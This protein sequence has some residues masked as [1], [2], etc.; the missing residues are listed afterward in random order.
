MN[1]F[2][3]KQISKVFISTPIT[4]KSIEIPL[5][6]RDYAQGRPEEKLRRDSFLTN[7]FNTINSTDNNAE[8]NLDF[9]YG[10]IKNGLFIPLD[11]QQRLTTLILL[12]FYAAIRENKLEEFSKIP[13]L[14]YRTR[15]SSKEFCESL[16]SNIETLS[17]TIQN[18][19][20]K[21]PISEVIKSQ[22]WY[23]QSYSSDNTIS[24]MLVMLDAIEDKYGKLNYPLWD[25]LDRIKFKIFP[26]DGKI[27]A[28]E[29]Y[30]KMNA[31][32]KQL[33]NFDNFKAEIDNL[34]EGKESDKFST[35]ATDWEDKF[36]EYNKSDTSNKNL[37][38]YI[39]HIMAEV[40]IENV[41]FNSDKDNKINEKIFKTIL[42]TDDAEDKLEFIPFQ[43]YVDWG[44]LGRGKEKN[45]DVIKEA[46]DCLLKFYD[47]YNK[48]DKTDK[49]D[50]IKKD[51]L[52]SLSKLTQPEKVLLTASI[53]YCIKFGVGNKN[54]DRWIRVIGNLM[55]NQQID[56]SESVAKAI[57]CI[58][59]LIE[60]CQ[61]GDIDEFL[62]SER[63]E[64]FKSEFSGFSEV[65]FNEER[66]KSLIIRQYPGTKEII[67]HL[68]DTP[69]IEGKIGFVLKMAE[70]ISSCEDI[71][72][73]EE[74]ITNLESCAK[75]VEALFTYLSEETDNDIND[76]EFLWERALFTKCDY[77]SS[78]ALLTQKPNR[79]YSWKKFFTLTKNQNNDKFN[80]AIDILKWLKEKNAC[81]NIKDGLRNIVDENIEKVLSDIVD[82]YNP[83]CNESLKYYT[84][85]IMLPEMLRYCKNGFYSY[86]KIGENDYIIY[87][88]KGRNRVSTSSVSLYQYY[89]IKKNEKRLDKNPDG[90]PIFKI[91]DCN[92]IFHKDGKPYKL[93]APTKDNPEELQKQR[94]LLMKEYDNFENIPSNILI[95]N[96]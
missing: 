60:Q 11:G 34:E 15:F 48:P 81:E 17:N 56:N 35:K 50:F 63:F 28:D 61:N 72:Y 3:L 41:Y 75:T 59:R 45:V 70:I 39:R 12:H 65:Q 16:Y 8:L 71:N 19:K 51:G 73:N 22:N 74:G 38:H 95:Q 33:N 58:F 87:L 68:E 89:F 57:H 5:I 20:Y 79:D 90:D 49:I 92:I 10:E 53:R 29:L 47:T 23:Y 26:L 21:A 78:K 25:K 96:Q 18:A 31:R 2:T 7:I 54:Y 40:F 9:T 69:N 6:Q 67:E 55:K 88:V 43:K 77:T 32:G 1:N 85:F 76:R 93:K 27:S 86:D 64:E 24:A 4:I 82:G 91:E 37:S 83:P 13:K 66:I 84:P 14:S 94:A 36:W 30:V 52:L 62:R 46:I 44:L 42:E 80:E